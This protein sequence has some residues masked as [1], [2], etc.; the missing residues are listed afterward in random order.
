MVKSQGTSATRSL[1]G[2]EVNSM[3]RKQI[4]EE[5]LL[6]IKFLIYFTVA[7]TACKSKMQAVAGL[8]IAFRKTGDYLREEISEFFKL[9]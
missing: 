1:V 3:Q 8:D 6:A 7:A 4:D 9:V 2:R 5:L